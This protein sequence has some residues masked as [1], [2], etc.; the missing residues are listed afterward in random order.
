MDTCGKCRHGLRLGEVQLNTRTVMEVFSHRK[1]NKLKAP[2]PQKEMSFLEHLEELRWTILRSFIYIVVGAII[3]FMMKGFVFENIIFAHLKEGFPTYKFFCALSDRMCV[4]PPKLELMTRQMGEQFFVHIKVSVVLGFIFAFPF[5][6]REIWKFVAP[7][8]KENEKKVTSSII[9]IC[10]GLFFLGVMFGYFVLAPFAIKFFAEYTV[11]DF[12]KTAPT[13]DSYVSF[14]TMLTLPV[15]IVFEL[16]VVAYFLAKIG[17]ISS[18][19]MK[20]YRKH[21][22]IFI[23]IIA[24]VI[25]PPDV[26]TQVLIGIPIFLIYEV[27]IYVVKRVEKKN[28][29]ND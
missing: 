19:L 7:G 5:V 15:G 10:S 6:F 11:G 17:I 25:T 20:K 12:A 8:L 28:K 13:L 16:P 27:S 3:V 4:H 29:E 14:L 26:F 18:S 23:L 22:I 21:A 1:K 9:A 2:N 24:A